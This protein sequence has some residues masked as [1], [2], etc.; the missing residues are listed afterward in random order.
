MALIQSH[1]TSLDHCLQ[2][3]KILSWSL[4]LEKLTKQ[5]CKFCTMDACTMAQLGDITLSQ[6]LDTLGVPVQRSC[7]VSSKYHWNFMARTTIV[8]NII[9]I[10]GTCN[11]VCPRLERSAGSISVRDSVP[12]THKVQYLK[13]GRWYS[14]QTWTVSSSMDCS[15]FIDIPC[16]LSG[17]GSKCRTYKF[18]PY[19]DFDAARAFCVSQTCLVLL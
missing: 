3:C 16:P 13:F 10:Q 8:W 5:T 12:L 6:S 14:Y 7:E 18:L 11:F 15:H 19:F 1:N 2:M 9:Q 17:A 4:N